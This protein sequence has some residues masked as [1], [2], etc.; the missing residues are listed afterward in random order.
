MAMPMFGIASPAALQEYGADYGTPSV[1]YVCTGPYKFVEWVTDDHIT[2]ARNADYWGEI[3]G[4][5]ETIV[6]RVIPDNSARFLALQAGEIHGMEQA[7]IEDLKSAEESEDVYV[8]T[9]PAL[10]TAYLAFNYKIQEFNDPNVRMAI[11][12]AIDQ[13]GIVEAFYGGYGEAA[14]NFLPPVIWGHNDAVPGYMYDPD[15][16]VE[17]LAEAGFADGLSEVTLED[18]SKIPLTL[19]YMPVVRFYYPDPEAIGEAMAAQLAA[20]GIEAKLELAGDWPTYLDMRRNGE[21]VGLYQLGWGGDNGDPDNFLGYFF[22]NIQEPK[23]SEGFIQDAEVADKLVEARVNTDKAERQATY[24]EVEQMLY[25]NA[26]RIWI[27]HNK[28]PLIFRKEVSGY[29]PNAVS[30]DLYKYVTVEQ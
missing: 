7:N 18:G 26:Y 17:L 24:E 30:D 27:A 20:V 22:S 13:E 15:K 3:P 29:I 5:V 19:Y 9:R 4:N 23:A 25:D 6:V 12:Y 28:T 11:G 14:Q 1:G 10:N 16:A 21:L 2:M 8:L